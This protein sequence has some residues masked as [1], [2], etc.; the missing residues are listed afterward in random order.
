MIRQEMSDFPEPTEGAERSARGG[1]SGRSK[2]KQVQN[3]ASDTAS[4]KRRWRKVTDATIYGPGFAEVFEAYR[5]HLNDEH[6]DTSRHLM[7][8]C[9]DHLIDFVNWARD[10]DSREQWINEVLQNNLYLRPGVRSGVVAI[11]IYSFLSIKSAA[12]GGD[13]FSVLRDTTNGM[14]IVNRYSI[15]LYSDPFQFVYF[16]KTCV[17]G[18]ID[19]GVLPD[20][21]RVD[22]HKKVKPQVYNHEE[23]AAF[24]TMKAALVGH[25]D[26][27]DNQAARK[28]VEVISSHW[29]DK[30]Q[31]SMH[32]AFV[33]HV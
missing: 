32:S 28:Y 33:A 1:D 30:Q 11:L 20:N 19:A 14:G 8:L 10:S 31:V 3:D 6:I 9:L 29:L 23:L 15:K 26:S 18:L 25:L 22:K 21:E 12:T 4:K 2:R 24:H 17:S 13:M 16:L 27:G 5:S 7:S